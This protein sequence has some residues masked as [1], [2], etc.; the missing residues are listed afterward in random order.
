MYK[1][2][3]VKSSDEKTHANGSNSEVIYSKENTEAIHDSR[4]RESATISAAFGVLM[5][6]RGRCVLSH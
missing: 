5:K 1:N 4:E 3:A 6:I 2:S